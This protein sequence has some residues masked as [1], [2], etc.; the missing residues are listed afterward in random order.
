MQL[1]SALDVFLQYGEILKTNPN[2]RIFISKVLEEK[3]LE[4]SNNNE[5]ERV[6]AEFLKHF[7]YEARM[8]KFLENNG[9]FIDSSQE[10]EI[11]CRT[12]LNILDALLEN[13]NEKEAEKYIEKLL[14]NNFIKNSKANI[15]KFVES[16]EKEE[17]GIVFEIILS[18]NIENIQ[19]VNKILNKYKNK[20]GKNTELLKNFKKYDMSFKSYIK[21]IENIQKKFEVLGINIQI[22]AGNLDLIDLNKYQNIKA[23]DPEIFNLAKSILN[24]EGEGNFICGLGKSFV[25]IGEYVNKNRIGKEIIRSQVGRYSEPFS[26]IIEIFGLSQQK[27]NPENN[28]DYKYDWY[29]HIDSELLEFLNIADW[30]Q[31]EDKNGKQPSITLHARLR[32]IDRFVLDSKKGKSQLKDE[33]T[34]EKLHEVVRVIYAQTPIK[35]EKMSDKR[36]VAFFDYNGDYIK[37]VFSEG[38]ELLTVIKK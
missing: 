33:K 11:Y 1:G 29:K 17:L 24:P 21:A 37:A 9:I 38:G 20:D 2:I 19:D 15:V 27:L 34:K 31:L 3:Q 10:S 14:K 12:C 28:P 8:K 16:K 26:N 25:E 36:F 13:K 7:K 22:N 35:V 30:L 6:Q 23:N 18:E 32:L 5:V 4:N